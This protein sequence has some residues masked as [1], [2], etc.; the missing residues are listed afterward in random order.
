ML[1]LKE[2]LK[3]HVSISEADSVLA[4]DTFASVNERG[5]GDC[6]GSAC[7]GVGKSAG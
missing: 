4:W 1:K 2:N 5:G 7:H 6:L 3:E